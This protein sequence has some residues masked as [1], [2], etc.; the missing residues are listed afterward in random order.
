M[1][2]VGSLKDESRVYQFYAFLQEKGIDILYESVNENNKTVFQIWVFE[3]DQ[4][5]EAAAYFVEFVENPDHEKFK[6]SAAKQS[7]DEET[8]TMLEA[9]QIQQIKERIMQERA[10]KRRHS[11]VTRL[12]ILVC[13]ILFFFTF[14]G[15]YQILK[16]VE[17]PAQVEQLLTPLD[18][19]LMFDFPY[20]E[21]GAPIDGEVWPGLY[22]ILVSY[23]K[24]NSLLGAPMF[25][26]ISQGQLWRLITPCLLHGGILHIL[27]NMMWLWI[28]GRQVEERIG[29]IRYLSIML[30]IGIISNTS[31][32]FMSGFSF[33]GYSG[34]ICGLAGFIWIRQKVAPW[35]GYPLQKGTVFF[36]MIF[37]LGITALQIVSFFLQ[38][39]Q[40]A[41]FPLYIA[42]TAH[43][44]GAI[45]GIILAKIPVFSR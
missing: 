33:V 20:Q 30:I 40:L 39:F 26:K 25:V 19:K 35:E 9:E 45:V 29:V 10:L 4:F 1:R 43:V 15:R 8:E 31:Q 7:L 23:P 14:Y 42:N 28:L 18:K 34:I 27:F 21:D 11:L 22:D 37:V 36:L 6:V 13:I 16:D 32:Y 44:V 24:E 38:F 2:L 41:S 12:I 3:E 5:D 17:D